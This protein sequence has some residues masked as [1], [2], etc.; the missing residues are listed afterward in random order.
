[1][2]PGQSFD[3]TPNRSRTAGYDVVEADIS[4]KLY[5]FI[6]INAGLTP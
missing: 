6:D 5:N 4:R 3:G 1:M 2:S